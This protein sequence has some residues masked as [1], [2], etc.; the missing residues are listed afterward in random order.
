M[1]SPD[2]ITRDTE[3]LEEKLKTLLEENAC[4][5]LGQL[6][7]NGKDMAA[8]GL[9]GPAIGETLHALLLQ[10]ARGQLPN[11]REALLDAAKRTL[12]TISMS[13]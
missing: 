7:V 8:L 6:T 13:K 1:E 9:R 3:A 5:T 12:Y 2:A 4:Y 11:D 10:V